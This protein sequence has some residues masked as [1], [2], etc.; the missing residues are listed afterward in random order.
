MPQPLI[1]LSSM[2]TRRILA[3][4]LEGVHE[5]TGITVDLKAMGGVDAANRVREGAEADIVLLAGGAMRKLAEEGHLIAASLTPFALSGMA[6]AIPAA[7]PVPDLSTGAAVRAAMLAGRVGYSTGPSGDHLKAL[8]QG[9]GIAEAM[10][11]RAVQAPPGVP[12]A[13]L[14]ASGKA[15][16]GV[17][18]LSELLGQPG[19]AIAGPLPAEIQSTTVFTAGI[20][21]ASRHPEAAGR[22][23][24][25]LSAPETA[26]VKARFG[27]AQP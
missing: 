5:R 1:L 7:A 12:V 24:G 17:Q 22:L 25:L 9:W 21:S 19:I 2:A 10:A 13:S 18:Q 6:I 14:V 20:A 11:E 15:D 27:M 26:P 3:V 8:W 23:L 16:L 4:L